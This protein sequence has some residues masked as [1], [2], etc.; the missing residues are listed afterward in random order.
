MNEQELATAK[1]LSKINYLENSIKTEIEEGNKYTQKILDEL[2]EWKKLQM[3]GETPEQVHDFIRAR[4][5]KG[6]RRTRELQARVTRHN[7]RLSKV[8]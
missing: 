3:W 4:I 5:I 1:L 8:G 2:A 6:Q 7:K